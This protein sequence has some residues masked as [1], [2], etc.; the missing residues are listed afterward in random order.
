[1]YKKIFLVL[2]TILI[3]IPSLALSYDR[4]MI[5]DPQSWRYGYGTIDEATISVHPKGV[6]MEVGLYLT[7]SARNINFYGQTQ[8]EVEFFFD[9]PENAMVTDSWLW[10]GKD[11]IR[12]EIMDKWTAGSIYEDIVNRRR[13][14]SILYKRSATQYELRIYPLNPAETR[15]VKITYLVPAQWATDV[16]SIPVPTNI[17]KASN[18]QLNKLHFLTWPENEWTNP[19]FTEFPDIQ[20]S[21][22]SDTL[23]GDYMGAAVPQEAIQSSLS[24]SFDSPLKYGIYLNTFTAKNESYY[25]LAFMP[26]QALKINSAKKV[27]VLVD[28]DASKS[29]ITA[30]ELLQTIKSVLISSLGDNDQFNL[31][32]SKLAIQRVSETWLSADDQ[33]IEQIFS[34]LTSDAIASDS[35]L[36]ALLGNGIQFVK[37]N[38]YD[39]SIVLATS[40]DQAGDF[41]V[42]NQLIRDIVSIM[43]PKIPIH[44]ADLQDLSYSYH[45][46]GGL[47]YYGNDY[48]YTNLTRITS[49]N[50]ARRRNISSNAEVLRRIF[51]SLGGFLPVFD[52]HTKLRDGICYGRYDISGIEGTTYLNRPILQVG[53]FSGN[54]P[55]MIEASGIFKNAIFTQNFEVDNTG[56][57]S[58]DSTSRDIWAGQYIRSLEQTSQTNE[59]VAQLIDISVNERILSTYTAFICLE[60]SMG[61]QICY[62]CMDEAG[63]LDITDEM[64]TAGEDSTFLVALPNPF[65][66]GT[67]IR[68]NL[69]KIT[70]LQDAG[71]RPPRSR[72]GSPPPAARGTRAAGCPGRPWGRGR[73]PVC[74]RWPPPR[75]APGTGRSCRCRS[76]RRTARGCT[77]RAT[78]TAP[79]PPRARRCADR[80]ADRVEDS[81]LLESCI[82]GSRA[83]RR[84]PNQASRNRGGSNR[85]TAPCPFRPSSPRSR[86]SRCSPRG[87][88]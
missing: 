72:G 30:A 2:L 76:C 32:F 27:V 9:L 17:L 69:K 23:F 63:M 51:D 16:V 68:V 60:P 79:G 34:Q 38:G 70:Q 67:T 83:G 13:D 78:R 26:S 8:V 54:P 5:R 74:R 55:F 73:W 4:L 36:P 3:I 85:K 1:M 53:K 47:T 31:I 11:I 77:G 18:Y 59:V 40:S 56:I 48:L 19:A 86:A 46:I 61:G 50:Y 81:E 64:E 35:N 29:S 39:A 21:S 87:R 10:V 84:Y 66:A 80:P 71:P 58:S 41:E 45:S 43:D 37:D 44:I 12:A 65:N 25:Q 6:Y 15:K 75:A 42:A 57:Y 14:P 62:D 49:G 22:Y 33:T 20:F 24:F 7:I 28:Y 88:S 82:A 52:L